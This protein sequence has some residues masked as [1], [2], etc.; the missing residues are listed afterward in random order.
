VIY[1]NANITV[2][3]ST[4][5]SRRVNSIIQKRREAGDRGSYTIHI[6][7]FTKEGKPIHFDLRF[8]I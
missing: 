6:D 3:D 5:L 8:E 4:D 1:W 7:G 2:K